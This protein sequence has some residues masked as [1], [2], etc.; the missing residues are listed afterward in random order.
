MAIKRLHIVL[1]KLSKYDDAGYIIRF[2]WG[3]LPSNTLHVLNG[4]TED[5]KEQKKLDPVEITTSAFDETVQ[6]VPVKDI[7]AESKKSDTMTLICLVGVQTNQFPRAMDLAKPFRDAYLPVIMGGFHT[8]GTINMISDQEPEIQEMVDRGITVISGEAEGKWEHILRAAL[9][10]KLEP[11]YSFAQDLKNLPDIKESAFPVIHRN[12]MKYY[13]FSGMA[14]I[15]T[16]RGCPFACSFCTI[17][18]VQGRTMRA[19]SPENFKRFV[20]DNYLNHGITNY[21]ITDDNFKRNP[22]WREILNVLCDLRNKEGISVDF[23]AQ[24]DLARSANDFEKLMAEAGCT[25]VFMGLESVNPENLKAEGKTQNKVE[26]FKE[27]I[28]RWHQ[29]NILVHAGY[30]IGLPFDTK[31]QVRLDVQ[32]LSDTLELDTVS[33]FMLTPLPGSHDHLIMKKQGVWMDPDFN[34]RDS[35][36]ATITHPR[37][38]GEEWTAAYHDAWRTFYSKENISR[39]LARWRHNAVVYRRQIWMSIWYKNA[40]LIEHEH[41]MIAGFFRLKDRTT[42]RPGFSIDSV[43]LHAAKRSRDILVLSVR[44]IKFF[45]ELRSIWQATRP[46]GEEKRGFVSYLLSLISSPSAKT[47]TMPV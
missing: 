13:A 41:P 26:Q 34:K 4:L 24:V 3:V 9:D 22:Q 11:I 18:N 6:F 19:R 27:I 1:I 38:T 20:R 30:I 40:S 29:N 14:T 25:Q 10:H 17:I 37:M 8:S 21:F 16:S 47:E 28:D 23:V 45:L 35:F 12:T 2:K 7:I 33:F 15:D 44:W 42:R 46:A 31:E 39:R 36:H 32:Y 43:L 5:I